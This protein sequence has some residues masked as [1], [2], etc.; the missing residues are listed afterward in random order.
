MISHVF[1]AWSVT[2]SVHGQSC[3]QYIVAAWSLHDQPREQ[4]IIA[5]R[6]VHNQLERYSQL[7]KSIQSQ[8]K[9][10][11]KTRHYVVCMCVWVTW[12]PK[13]SHW[14]FYWMPSRNSLTQ[15]SFAEY[16]HNSWALVLSAQ[17]LCCI[18]SL[19][20]SY[21]V[22]TLYLWYGRRQQTSLRWWHLRIQ[23]S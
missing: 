21:T 17:F 18:Q 7:M 20:I 5:T 6:S 14:D 15:V 8:G 13:K 19:Y 1:S 2:W 9:I 12:V 16:L 10:Q 4:C 22:L 3:D 11:D 23:L